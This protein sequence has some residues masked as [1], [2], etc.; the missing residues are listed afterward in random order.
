MRRPRTVSSNQYGGGLHHAK[1][2]GIPAGNKKNK[3][4]LDMKSHS[5]PS[6]D[7]HKK[8]TP[9]KKFGKKNNEYDWLHPKRTSLQ[10]SGSSAFG[11]QRSHEYS[12]SPKHSFGN[13]ER[14]NQSILQPQIKGGANAGQHSPGPVYLATGKMAP[15]IGNNSVAFSFPK[16]KER[17]GDGEVLNRLQVRPGPGAYEHEQSTEALHTTAPNYSFQKIGRENEGIVFAPGELNKGREG[18]DSPGPAYNTAG[19]TEKLS[20]QKKQGAFSFGGKNLE[21]NPRQKFG[22][23]DQGGPA[24]VSGL[25]SV[26]SQPCSHSST[27][28][29][30][31]FGSSERASKLYYPGKLNSVVNGQTPGPAQ[32]GRSVNSSF[33]DLQMDSTHSRA[34]NF[35][36]SLGRRMPRDINEKDSVPGPG[37]YGQ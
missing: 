18:G 14:F 12:Q 9:P 10:N 32:E 31:I 34:P 6:L 3:K 29:R 7:T 36:M 30:T 24:S 13:G 27:A 11:L 28:P 25:G 4:R 2:G 23:D 33:G 1:K 21:R 37:S 5:T 35:S 26:G 16:R 17:V 15:V 22:S 20:K 8:R 19:L